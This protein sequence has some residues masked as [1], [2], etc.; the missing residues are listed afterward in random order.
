MNRRI[1]HRYATDFWACSQSAAEWFYR[2]D[3]M[4]RVV[5]VRNAIDLER[6]A[7]NDEKRKQI[8]AQYGLEEKFLIGNVG[9][10]H[11]QKNQSFAL[12][13]FRKVLDRRE[14][15]HLVLI[16]QGEDEEKLKEEARQL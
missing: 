13:V 8:R 9:R 7:Y 11:H 4:D 6:L 3:L 12:K 2:D 14:D 10:L 16:G 5:L 15:A 1:I